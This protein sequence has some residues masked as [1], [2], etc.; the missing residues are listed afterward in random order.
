MNICI[1]LILL[2]TGFWTL[3]FNKHLDKIH[4]SLVVG[5]S[6]RPSLLVFLKITYRYASLK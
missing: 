4:A 1:C 3:P 2:D 5:K 6:D